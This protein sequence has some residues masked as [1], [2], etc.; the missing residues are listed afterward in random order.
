MKLVLLHLPLALW[1]LSNGCSPDDN[2][3]PLRIS[4]PIIFIPRLVFIFTFGLIVC[5]FAFL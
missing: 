5:A 1:P 2:D 4:S 3:P